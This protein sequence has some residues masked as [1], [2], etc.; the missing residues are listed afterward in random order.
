MIT[1]ISRA[2]LLLLIVFIASVYIPKFYWMKFEKNVKGNFVVY[3]PIKKDFLYSNHSTNDFKYSDKKGNNYD[4][5][6]FEALTPLFNYRQLLASGKMPDSLNGVKLNLEA[7]KINNFNKKI[8]PQAID[9]WFVPLNPLMESK[10]G[11][12]RL[13]MPEDF[14]RID[15]RMEF[16]D[17][18]TNKVDEAKSEKFTNALK[19]QKFNFP[20]KIIAGNPTTKKPFDEGYF[21]L[22]SGNKLFQIKMIKGEPFCVDTHIP[23]DL[24]IIYITISESQLRETYGMIVTADNSVYLISYDKYKLIKVPING[25][26][27]KE[28]SVQI[29]GDL[30]YRVFSIITENSNRSF[31]T[32]RKYRLLDTLE[33]KWPDKFDQ[34]AGKVFKYLFPFSITLTEDTSSFVRI[35]LKI[36]SASCFILTGFL[37]ILTFGIMFKRKISFTKSWFDFLLVLCTGIYG[38]LAILLIKRIE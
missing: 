15:K 29:M 5:D 8:Q 20:A 37:L 26:N 36:N 34:T 2:L 18:R 21:V 11:R 19:E 7:I 9:L 6:Q 25:Y 12:V 22:D 23:A 4:R 32:D 33:L 24:N 17:C 28:A 38:F 1:K 13:E 31:V 27:Y 16:I 14:F 10:S 3:S 30:F 35:N